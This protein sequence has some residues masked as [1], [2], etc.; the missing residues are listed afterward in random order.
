MEKMTFQQ[1]KETENKLRWKCD[2]GGVNFEFY[3]P[4]ESIPTTWP[5]GIKVTLSENELGFSYHYHDRLITNPIYADIQK[6]EKHTETIRYTPIGEESSWEIGQPYI[7]FSL[8]SSP[9]PE[10]LYIKVEW[11]YSRGNW[12]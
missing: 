5:Q 12:E 3:I 8:L 9:P 4:K 6:D 11:D 2:V 1:S 10:V 7:P